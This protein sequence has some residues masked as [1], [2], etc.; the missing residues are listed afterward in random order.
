VLSEAY[1]LLFFKVVIEIEAKNRPGDR[2]KE[3]YVS[4]RLPSRLHP[5]KTSLSSHCARNDVLFPMKALFYYHVR[6]LI[7]AT[8]AAKH[9]RS[10]ILFKN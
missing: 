3:F 6:G 8:G 9:E 4:L 5:E 10:F 1:E 7:L 2:M